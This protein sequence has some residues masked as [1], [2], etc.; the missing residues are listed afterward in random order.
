MN[1][2]PGE[3]KE[4]Y[5]FLVDHTHLSTVITLGPV[6]QM[7]KVRLKEVVWH[8]QVIPAGGRTGAWGGLLDFEVLLFSPWRRGCTSLEVDPAGADMQ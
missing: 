2:S 7:R 4:R 8:S 1:I 5:L 3:E 6:S